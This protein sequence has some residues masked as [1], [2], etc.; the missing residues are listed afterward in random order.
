[1]QNPWLN[2]VREAPYILKEDE[3][4]FYQIQNLTN[5]VNL[6]LFDLFMFVLGL[7]H[8]EAE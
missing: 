5:N 8:D 2:M 4:N 1:M 7:V 6:E 3:K